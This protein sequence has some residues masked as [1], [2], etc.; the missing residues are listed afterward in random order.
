MPTKLHEQSLGM[1]EPRRLGVFLSGLLGC[2]IELGLSA[3]TLAQPPA[4]AWVLDSGWNAVVALEPATGR[5]LAT[6]SVKGRPDGLLLSPDGSRLVVLERGPGEDK[7]E[8]GYK[9]KGK[10]AATIIDTA[11]MQIVGRVELGFGIDLDRAY[12]GLDRLAMFCPGYEDKKLAE[13]QARELVVLGLKE[14]REVGRVALEHGVV[15]ID[16]AKDGHTLVLVQGLPRT[17]KYPYPKARVWF[18]DISES[19]V[20]SSVDASGWADLYSDGSWLYLLDRGKPD[21]DPRKNRNG[22]LQVVS[23]ERRAVA[24]SLDAGREPRGLVGDRESQDVFIASD[25]PPDRLNGEVRVVRGES[26][27]ATTRV[28][29]GPR[30][31]VRRQALVIVVSA[32]AVTFM[33]PVSFQVTATIPLSRGTD[34]LVFDDDQPRELQV[35]PDGRRAFVLYDPGQKLVVL[36][37][38]Q[39]KLL[40]VAGTGRGGRRFLQ[41][42][43]RVAAELSSMPAPLPWWTDAVGVLAY[44]YTFRGVRTSNWM[45]AVRPDSLFAYVLNPRTSDVTIVDSTSAAAVQKIGVGGY[46]LKALG[47]GAIVAVMSD[48]RIHLLE[49][50]G[51]RKLTELRLHSLRDVGVS[52]DGRYA[53]A[54]ADRTVLCLDG[55]TGSVIASLKDFVAP[56]AVVFDAVPPVP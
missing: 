36:D 1:S 9:A 55:V 13:A 49:T 19:T 14:G 51:N 2:W 37:L 26:V 30:L 8:R 53:L 23:L 3:V 40:G 6:L 28:A 29:A 56:T 38:E 39:Q 16:L 12:F 43:S 42:I 47:G 15:P 46:R 31:L 24:S 50:T 17:G 34:R 4:R 5:R 10:S 41:G 32:G 27:V 11:A 7:G 18:A 22:T 35:S 20:E 52:P 25:G 54:L 45:L 48:S 44:G 21:R 33:E